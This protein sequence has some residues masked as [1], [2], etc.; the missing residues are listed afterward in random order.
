VAAR[1]LARN[2]P[3]RPNSSHCGPNSMHEGPVLDQVKGT[4]E[5]SGI[6]FGT[7]GCYT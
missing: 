4:R 6:T 5:G 3:A 7:E 2:N 1:K